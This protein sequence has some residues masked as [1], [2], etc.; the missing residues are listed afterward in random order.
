MLHLLF[1]RLLSIK[2]EEF[3]DREMSMVS[4]IMPAYNIEKFI[5][6]AILTVSEIIG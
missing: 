5:A 3:M 6:Q 1:G 2:L 4:V